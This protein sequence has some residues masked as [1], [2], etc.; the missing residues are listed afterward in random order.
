MLAL[1]GILALVLLSGCARE[2]KP[3]PAPT[4]LA[5]IGRV[6]VVGFDGLEPSLVR[7]WT[8]EGK[9]PN[10]KRLMENGAF[11]E[12]ES[13][14]PPSSAP[15]W[16]SA[17]TGVNPGKHG[18]FGFIVGGLPSTAAELARSA[19][20][21]TIF[22]TS[23][24]RGFE[25]VWDVLGR[26]GRKSTI[27][28][29]PLT[30]P[31][32][33][34]NGV[35]VSGF[36]YTSDDTSTYYWPKSL[37]RYLGGYTYDAF[38]ETVMRGREREFLSDI[39]ASTE[40]K[41]RL[42]LTLFD[43]TAW[44]LFWLV[45][46]FT[47]TYQHHFWKYMDRNH[48]MYDAEG[49]KIYGGAIESAYLRADAYLGQFM[50]KMRDSDL[51]VTMSD[52]G[53]GPVYYIVNSSNFIAHTFGPTSDITC[54]DFFGCKYRIVT[55]GLNAEE[56]Y[57]SL[58]S[59]LVSSLVA[60]EDPQR[61]AKILDSVYVKEQIYRGP[62]IGSAPDVVGL[63]RDGYLFFKL[64]PTPDRRLF[65][66]GP[67]PDRMF[68]GFHRRFGVLGLYGKCV[69]PGLAFKARI[70]DVSPIIFA[71]LGVPAPFAIDGKVPAGIFIGEASGRTAVVRS[72]D[73]GYRRPHGL[74]SQ[75]SKR[76]EK[77]LRAVGYIQ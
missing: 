76:I 77:Q 25:T 51:L 57:T 18:V 21:P 10:F 4:A 39:D 27:I 22:N 11:G 13:S 14:M 44:D 17:V 56:R 65:D 75:D 45:F 6:I 1:A 60:L 38:G 55:S 19:A 24:N 58:R 63:E 7:K 33:S 8:A 69:S 61:G 12:L 28:N 73:P 71:Y 53:F 37:A 48:P 5:A 2:Q 32:D 49:A 64:P 43:E 50:A 34:L 9:L 47:D 46:T 3:Q 30:S 59:T 26:F 74:T 31:A 40:Q 16:T 42:G 52:H 66:A 72:P 29:I 20:N 62:Y 36:P 67:N 68:S 54:A 41:L 23:D 70:I 35:M 15:A